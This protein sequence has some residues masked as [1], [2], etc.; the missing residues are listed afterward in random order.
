MEERFTAEQIEKAD[1]LAL[2][3]VV[4]AAVF[5]LFILLFGDIM[6]EFLHIWLFLERGQG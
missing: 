1:R 2:W 6:A 4:S 3:L 5:T